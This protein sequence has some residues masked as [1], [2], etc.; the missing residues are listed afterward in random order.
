MSVGA[1]D[2]DGDHNP[3]GG[4]RSAPMRRP[5]SRDPFDGRPSADRDDPFAGP[6]GEEEEEQGDNEED[7]GKGTEDA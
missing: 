7:G 3:F 1:D 5:A 2:E 4:G 6:G